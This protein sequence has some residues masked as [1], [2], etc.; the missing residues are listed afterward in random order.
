MTVKGMIQVAVS[1]LH[2][3][4]F[5]QPPPSPPPL[6]TYLS[7]VFKSL[8]VIIRKRCFLETRVKRK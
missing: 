6:Y 8:K 1:L 3:S 4:L 2:L 7:V 5:C